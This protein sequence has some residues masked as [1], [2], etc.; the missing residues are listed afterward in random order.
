MWTSKLQVA[1]NFSGQIMSNGKSFLKA[2]S[3]DRG[4]VATEIVRDTSIAWL[5]LVVG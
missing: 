4:V 1:C 3:P 5:E 2:I